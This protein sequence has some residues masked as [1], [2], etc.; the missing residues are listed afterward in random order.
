MLILC[1]SVPKPIIKLEPKPLN[2]TC[3]T[4]QFSHEIKSIT[5][6]FD[7]I[8]VIIFSENDDSLSGNKSVLHEIPAST[9]KNLTTTV[10]CRLNPGFTYELAAVLVSVSEK[11]SPINSTVTT[12]LFFYGSLFCERKIISSYR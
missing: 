2:E 11:S 1:I 5:N 6:Q 3:I 9:A 4:I 12:S 8:E 7:S 10:V